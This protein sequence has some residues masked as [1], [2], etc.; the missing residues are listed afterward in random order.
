[1]KILPIFWCAERELS[2]RA[3]LAEHGERAGREL[4]LGE[5]SIF[6]PR[7]DPLSPCV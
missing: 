3:V 7:G 5:L 6:G 4:S 1:M 2:S